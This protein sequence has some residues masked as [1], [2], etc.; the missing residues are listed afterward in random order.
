MEGL[1]RHGQRQVNPRS[2]QG[3]WWAQHRQRSTPWPCQIDFDA[4]APA[5][6]SS[7]T[8]RE[9]RLSLLQAAHVAQSGMPSMRRPSVR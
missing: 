5:L 7:Q 8:T 2:G 3:P 4:G 9:D 1:Q 6:S